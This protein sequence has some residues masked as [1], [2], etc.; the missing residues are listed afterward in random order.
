[1]GKRNPMTTREALEIIQY[2][3]RVSRDRI[4]QARAILAARIEASEARDRQFGM[5]SPE[6]RASF[7]QAVI[8]EANALERARELER[9]E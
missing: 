5:T 2:H 7:Q 8:D 1:M 9:G 4:N 3:P 6:R